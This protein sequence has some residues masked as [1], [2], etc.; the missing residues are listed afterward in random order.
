MALPCPST[1]PLLW[2]LEWLGM[3]TCV[4][5][6]MTRSEACWVSPGGPLHSPRPPGGP[7]SRT[8]NT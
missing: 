5:L 4:L 1:S 7:S 2:R 3:V 6:L 8:L